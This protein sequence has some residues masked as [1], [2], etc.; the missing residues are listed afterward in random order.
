[1]SPQRERIV[2]CFSNHKSLLCDLGY[3]V[4]GD[5][6]NGVHIRY[7][8]NGRLRELSCY[9]NGVKDGFSVRAHGPANPPHYAHFRGGKPYGEEEEFFNGGRQM[10][11]NLVDGEEKIPYS[12]EAAKRYQG[13]L[14]TD[15]EEA[16]FRKYSKHPSRVV[17]M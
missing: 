12:A 7:W 9:C 3:F 17:F 14:T 6:R 1:M 4:E 5:S 13:Y 16:I 2:A 15:Q 11:H 8:G 10:K